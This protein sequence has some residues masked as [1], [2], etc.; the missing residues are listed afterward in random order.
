MAKKIKLFNSL[1]NWI[2][3]ALAAGRGRGKGAASGKSGGEKGGGG[4]KGKEQP[5][6]AKGKD[7]GGEKGG[8]GDKGHKDEQSPPSADAH[9]EWAVFAICTRSKILWDKQLNFLVKYL[10]KFLIN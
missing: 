9:K 6:H 5:G 7:K 3:L 10:N 2:F 4:A 8:K 1:V